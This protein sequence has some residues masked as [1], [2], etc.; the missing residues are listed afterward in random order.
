[1]LQRLTTQANQYIFIFL[2]ITK[3]TLFPYLPKQRS[4]MKVQCVCVGGKAGG[5][6][7]NKIYK[8]L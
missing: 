4:Y 2:D 3:S 6:G 1:M 5:G 8:R 7:M